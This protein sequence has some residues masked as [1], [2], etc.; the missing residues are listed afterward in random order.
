MVRTYVAW[1]AL[2]LLLTGCVEQPLQ[3]PATA[4]SVVLGKAT[5]ADIERLYGPPDR[6]KKYFIT[7]ETAGATKGASPFDLAPVAGSFDEIL[8]MKIRASYGAIPYAE[9]LAFR[10]WN[11]KLVSYLFY[12]NFKRDSREI[13]ESDLSSIIEG[14]TTVAEFE[15]TLGTPNSIATY[16]SIFSPEFRVLTYTSVRG[17]DKGNKMEW[18]LRRLDLLVDQNGVV[19]N[20]RFSMDTLTVNAGR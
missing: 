15:R 19:R 11:D 4:A 6:E 3:E 13:K 14:K 16:P 9:S 12:S 7:S 5:P 10:F 8:Y 20:H 1:M 18:E 2:L 17:A